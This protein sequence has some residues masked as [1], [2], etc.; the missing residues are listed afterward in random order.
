MKIKIL[1][2]AILVVITTTQAQETVH[3][4]NPDNFNMD[5]SEYHQKTSIYCAQLSKV[6]YWDSL[7]IQKLHQNLSKIYP[8]ANYRWDFIDHRDS[9][10]HTQ[11]LL[12]GS[13]DFVIIAFRGTEPSVIKDWIT[14]AKFWNYENQP[15]SNEELANMPAGHGGFRRSLIDLITKKKLFE[16]IDT[17]IR[18]GNSNKDVSKTPI[19]LTGH[20][21]GAAISQLFIEPLR[22]KKYNFSGAYHFAPPLAVSCKINDY[23]KS[24]FQNKV[25]DIV[26]YKDYVPRAGRNGVAH[27]G[28]FYRICKNGMMYSEK[29]AYI[30]FRFFEYFRVFTYHS[31]KNYLKALKSEKNSRIEINKRSVGVYPCLR[32]KNEVDTCK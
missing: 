24:E 10:S 22:Y 20:S 29:E 23:M 12:L 21:L 3:D 27:F 16:R 31:L 5:F 14:D 7:G 15:C 6:A 30:K 1:L 9:K 18:N 11:V 28:K 25:Y 8:E 4:L 2:L 32:P 13:T 19:Y 26:N 17:F